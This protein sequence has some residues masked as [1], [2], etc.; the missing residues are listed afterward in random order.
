M[1]PRPLL[2]FWLLAAAPAQDFILY[3]F[4]A[5]CS[6]EVVNHAR[7]P[8]AFAGNG[9]LESNTGG[10]PFTNGRFREA[11]AGG[12]PS[13]GHYN[14]VRTGWTPSTQP[15]LGDLTMSFWVR[16]RTP[17]STISYFSG[18]SW[19]SG[20]RLFTGGPAGRGL[21]QRAV[22]TSGGNGASPVDLLL[23]ESAADVQSLAAARWTHIA[24]VV[25]STAGTVQWYVDGA[26]VFLLPN[27]G[28]ARIA[29]T[30]EYMIGYQSTTNE[31]NYDHD[32][33]LISNRAYTSSEVQDL[34]LAPRAG[35][36]VF[37]SGIP[38]QCGTATL[39]SYGGRP[40]LGNG[41]YGLEIDSPWP[42]FYL[43]VLGYSRCRALNVTPLPVELTL[44]APGCWLLTDVVA[45]R[46]G[47]A[48]G[49][50]VRV[51][52]PI[53]SDPSYADLRLNAQAAVFDHV[54]V[55]GTVSLH[56]TM[57]LAIDLGR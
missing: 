11:L 41:G 44:Y 48:S 38:G 30:G 26:P 57:G 50:P 46:G 14:R 28:P 47:T 39:R 37:T 53:P 19:S 2:S 32:E 33:Y 34:F 45:S 35:D 36:G 24:L 42:G 31:S 23:P 29:S 13:L 15:L 43:L 4:D 20:T 51:A 5:A 56:A 52:M 54:T 3:K 8:G 40:A 9:I 27:V 22:V 16:Q 6:S 49:A 10:N 1:N 55:P 17:S 25:D 21:Y 7:G 12:D 18:T